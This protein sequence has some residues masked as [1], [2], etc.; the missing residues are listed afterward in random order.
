M[1]MPWMIGS[2]Q[3]RSSTARPSEAP[4]WALQSARGFKELRPNLYQRPSRPWTTYAHRMHPLTYLCSH[5]LLSIIGST[6]ARVMV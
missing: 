3:R 1:G 5:P 2:K 4:I 6:F